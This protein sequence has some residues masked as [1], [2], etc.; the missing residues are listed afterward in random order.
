LGDHL[1]LG[2]PLPEILPYLTLGVPQSHAQLA[3][4]RRYFLWQEVFQSC[5]LQPLQR[6]GEA[7]ESHQPQQGILQPA[8]PTRHEAVLMDIAELKGVPSP[9]LVSET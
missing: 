9:G 7:H 4:T 6:Y 3:N 5:F 2:R 8:L 1:W